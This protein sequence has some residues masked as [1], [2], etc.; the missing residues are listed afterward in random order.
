MCPCSF[1]VFSIDTFPK[2][3]FWRASSGGGG[4]GGGATQWAPSWKFVTWCD[5][6]CI[7]KE[8]ETQ[9]CGILPGFYSRSRSS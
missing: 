5:P 7:D 3:V 8:T 2:Q 1:P 9:R 6:H 4:G